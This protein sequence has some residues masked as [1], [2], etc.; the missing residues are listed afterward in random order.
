MKIN[1]KVRFK[2]KEFWIRLIIAVFGPILAYFGLS[3]D[4]LTT[5][6]SVGD[7]LINA[8]SNPAVIIAVILSVLNIFP[9]PTTAGLSDSKQALTYKAPRKDGF[10]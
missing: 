4:D 6:Q 2:S 7:L 5:W 8:V 9:D 10:K 1:W 3:I